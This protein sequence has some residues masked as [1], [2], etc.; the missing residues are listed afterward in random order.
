MALSSVLSHK[1]PD[2]LAYSDR[3]WSMCTRRIQTE[4]CLLF[5]CFLCGRFPCAYVQNKTVVGYFDLGEI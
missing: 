3:I 1:G 5:Q 4:I 2:N